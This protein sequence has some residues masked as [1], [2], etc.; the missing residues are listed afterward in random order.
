M[1]KIKILATLLLL[2]MAPLSQA[3][4][5]SAQQAGFNNALQKM[6][7]AEADYKTD[8]QAVADTEKLIEKKKK[9][10]AE[11]QK[12]AELSRKNYLEAREKLEQA[13]AALDKAW[14]E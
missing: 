14:K 9:Q 11:E 10:L 12:K 1:L 5:V 13:Q 2:V 4:D 6:E 3:K 7:K 8:A